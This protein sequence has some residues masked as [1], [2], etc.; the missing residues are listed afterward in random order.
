M[1]VKICL[2]LII[3]LSINVFPQKEH[4][5]NSINCDSLLNSE[6]SIRD[7]GFIDKYPVL[8]KPLSEVQNDF[9]KIIDTTGFN[10]SIYIRVFVDTLGNIHCAHLLKGNN[11]KLDSIAINYI[12][13]LKVFPAQYRNKKV[14][15]Y[16]VVPLLS[17]KITETK[18]LIK[19]SGKW[20]D[21]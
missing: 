1:N 3:I 16:V 13:K 14:S 9:L 4:S 18:T 7:G 5:H 12:S 10:N 15:M 19:K 21:K 6:R 11:N 20:Y 2:L 17:N 8:V